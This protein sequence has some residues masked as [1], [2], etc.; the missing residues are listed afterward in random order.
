[1]I[2]KYTKKEWEEE[3]EKMDIHPKFNYIEGDYSNNVF[4]VEG[5]TS[6]GVVTYIDGCFCPFIKWF[7]LE[8]FKIRR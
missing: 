8:Q 4:Q 2:I 6:I 7:T 5:S 1:M 3:L